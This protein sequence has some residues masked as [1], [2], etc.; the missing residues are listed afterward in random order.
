MNS[1]AILF[2]ILPLLAFVIVDSFST[3][4]TALIVTSILAI[5]EGVFSIYLFGELDWVTGLSVF[6]VLILA[7]L[8]Y[9]KK[10]STMIKF[11]PVVLGGVLGL[12]FLV[13]YWIGKPI[14][15]LMLVKYKDQLPDAIRFQVMNPP[16]LDLFKYTTHYAGYALIIH[17]GMMAYAALKWNKW[18]WITIRIVGFYLLLFLAVFAASYHVKEQMGM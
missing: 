9:Q 5:I 16:M 11:Q 2:G 13:S 14:F 17:A 18:I 7:F 10:S 1:G 3:M 8:S 4:K 15:Y 12:I 6:L